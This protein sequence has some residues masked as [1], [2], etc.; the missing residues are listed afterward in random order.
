MKSKWLATLTLGAAVAFAS[1]AVAQ[2]TCPAPSRLDTDLDGFD[3]AQEL[4]GVTLVSGQTVQTDPARKDAFIVVALAS[5]SLVQQVFG[6]TPFNPFTP[7][8]YVGSGVNVSFNGL[9]ALGL[10]V[11]MLSDQDTTPDRIV[12]GCG[13][14]TQKA[15]RIAESIDTNGTILGNCQWGTPNDLDGC[16][17]YSQRIKNFIDTTCPGNTPDERT[18]MFKAYITQSFLHEM[19]H[20][21]GGL[22]SQYNSRT[23]GYHY[24]T[25][26]GYVMDQSISYTAKSGRCTWTIA[27]LWNPA[28]DAQFVRLK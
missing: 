20:S 24:K 26:S 3:D 16:V 5:N 18:L 19:G 4:A 28:T 7:V 6:A 23:G 22:A 13:I 12:D 14:T 9:A 1:A 11:H 8:T 25:G 17:V 21:L 10:N 15:V 2:T 27:P